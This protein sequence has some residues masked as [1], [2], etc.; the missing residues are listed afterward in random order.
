MAKKVERIILDTNLWISFLIT[1]DLRKLDGRIRNKKVKL[2]FSLESIEEFLAVANRPKFKKYFTK[3][4]I[5]QL[6]DLFDS[7]GELVNVTSTVELSRDAKDNFLLALAKDGKADYLVTG[8][9]DLLS[10]ASVGKTKIITMAEYVK[11]AY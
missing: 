10:I 7:Y 5:E 9:K 6:I 1:G 3:A 2:I 11:S 8:D 4:D